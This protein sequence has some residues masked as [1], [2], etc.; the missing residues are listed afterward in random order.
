MKEYF[1]S[2]LDED[3]VNEIK[4]NTS[5]IFGR[6]FRVFL[7]CTLIVQFYS[8]GMVPTESMYP[9]LEID[10]LVLI[11]TR[12]TAPLRGDIIAFKSPIAGENTIYLK[13]VIGMPGDEIEIKDYHVYIDGKLIQED[14]IRNG[15]KTLGYP[16]VVIPSGHYFVM[17]DNRENSFDSR[18]YG[19]I[20]KESIKGTLSI[21]LLPIKSFKKF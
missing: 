18:N 5:Y 2:L 17:G 3:T 6:I 14:Y 11:N 21:R 7:I 9:T 20:T 8:V 16:K 10:N 12:E 19:F 1:K 4:K 13:R 15:A